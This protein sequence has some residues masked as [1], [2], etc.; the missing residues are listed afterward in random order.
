M[1]VNAR[2]DGDAEQQLNYLAEA[3]GL[4]VSEVLRTSVQHYY[5]QLRAQRGGLT[6]FAAFIG[7]GRSGRS[8]VAGSYKARLAEGWSAKHQGRAPAVHESAPPY[9]ADAESNKG[10]A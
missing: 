2:F 9:A 10:G 4:G 5:E 3:T 1:R 7:K 6:H 8:D